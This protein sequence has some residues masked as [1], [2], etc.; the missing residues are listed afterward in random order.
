MNK[1]VF[2]NE[3]GISKRLCNCKYEKL[4]SGKYRIIHDNEG[5]GKIIVGDKPNEMKCEKVIVDAEPNMN[6]TENGLYVLKDSFNNIVY[7]LNINVNN[8]SSHISN[9]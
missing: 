1:A 6:I 9:D 5:I 8:E 4:K 7:T 3:K 2:I